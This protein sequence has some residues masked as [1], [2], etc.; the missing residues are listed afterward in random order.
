[1]SS[2]TTAQPVVIDDRQVTRPVQRFEVRDVQ[3]A[4]WANEQWDGSTAHKA[5]VS[6]RYKAR[7]GTWRSSGSFG[8][9]DLPHLIAALQQA[10][11][12]ML[13]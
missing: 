13:E 4:V 9:Q 3:V 8:K 5:T 1:M 12:E 2:T 6:R 7:D 11:E 10:L